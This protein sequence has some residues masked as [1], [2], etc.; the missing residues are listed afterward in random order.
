[1]LDYYQKQQS[2]RVNYL[3]D[4]IESDTDIQGATGTPMEFEDT[5]RNRIDDLESGIEGSTDIMAALN[6][7]WLEANQAYAITQDGENFV[8]IDGKQLFESKEE[9]QSILEPKGLTLTEDDEVVAV[10]ENP[11]DF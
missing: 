9:L 1:V 7:V 10:G 6:V 4:S 3:R 2:Q 11:F 8:D 5:L